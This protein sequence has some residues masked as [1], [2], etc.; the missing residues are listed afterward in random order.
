ME[1]PVANGESDESMHDKSADYDAS[2]GNDVPPGPDSNQA[3]EAASGPK[4]KGNK[5]A[6]KPLGPTE[7]GTVSKMQ[8]KKK[9]RLPPNHNQLAKIH[10]RTLRR[11]SKGVPRNCVARPAGGWKG[12]YTFKGGDKK[13]CKIIGYN[14]TGTRALI[15]YTKGD[16]TVWRNIPARFVENKNKGTTD[17]GKFN[18]AAQLH[19]ENPFMLD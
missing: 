15:T 19:E 3:K 7:K 11:F 9:P 6:A 8:N 4:R 5:K 12:I 16:K 10:E 13:D 1:Q 14:H 2:P 17:E 18:A